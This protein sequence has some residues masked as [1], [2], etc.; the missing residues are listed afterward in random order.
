MAAFKSFSV[1]TSV[2]RA[3]KLMADYKVDSVPTLVVQGRWTTSPSIAGSSERALAVVD[4]L[5]QRARS[6]K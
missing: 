4:Q 5:I 6:G 2:G 1:S 3:K